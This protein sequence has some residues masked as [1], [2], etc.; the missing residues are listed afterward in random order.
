M[1]LAVHL[2]PIGYAGKLWFS[3]TIA[4]DESVIP[5][6]I[7]SASPFIKLVYPDKHIK[8][9]IKT[10]TSLTYT[11]IGGRNHYNN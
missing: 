5:L 2:V 1:L 3:I 8:I 6:I 9:I 4:T 7:I 10:I 11:H